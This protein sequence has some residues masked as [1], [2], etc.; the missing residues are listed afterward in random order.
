MFDSGW[1]VISFR[2]CAPI[3][4]PCMVFRTVALK[5]C[6]RTN[7]CRDTGP[8]YW[9]SYRN[10]PQLS[11]LATFMSYVWRDQDTI[12]VQIHGLP[13]TKR[14]LEPHMT[15]YF[16]SQLWWIAHLE[17]LI[18]KITSI[19]PRYCLQRKTMFYSNVR[20]RTLNAIRYFQ[21]F[22]RILDDR[23][24]LCGSEPQYFFYNE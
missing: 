23:C 9:R 12:G 7:A 17:L 5:V 19:T 21:Y 1:N 18:K 14:T 8:R 6:L 13:V 11:H 3:L 2:I 20:I 10:N 4:H 15:L 24:F 16:L 22:D